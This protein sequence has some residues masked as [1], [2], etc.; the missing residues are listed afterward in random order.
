MAMKKVDVS[1][2]MGDAFRI[3]SKIRNHELVADQSLVGGGKDAGPSPLE[4][5]FFSLGGCFC[6]LGRIIANQRRIELR[7]MDVRVTGEL[8]TSTLLGQST[9]NRAGFQRIR[10]IARIDADMTREEKIEFLREVDKRCPISD[11]VEKDTPITLE[12]E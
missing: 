3:D 2:K 6:T 5:L 8:D 7:G 12:V 4:Y 1:M 11:N 10:V 9:E